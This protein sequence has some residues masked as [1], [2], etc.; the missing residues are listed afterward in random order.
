MPAVLPDRLAPAP[1]DMLPSRA[2]RALRAHWWLLLLQGTGLLLLGLSALVLPVL[3]T[4]VAEQLFGW[5]FIAAGIARLAGLPGLR[6]MNGGAWLAAGSAAVSIVAG[7]LLL[8]QPVAGMFALTA[9]L[10]ALFL[11]DGAALVLL[12]TF[13]L[14][15]IDGPRWPSILPGDASAWWALACGMLDIALAGMIAIGWPGV[16]TWVVGTLLGV[17]LVLGGLTL[18]LTGIGLRTPDK[19]PSAPPSGGS[20]RLAP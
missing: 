14:T 5:I 15:R 17:N 9:M 6:H 7:S 8:L 4:L 1:G 18:V 19:R 12:A 13:C 3:A 2:V 10:A 11:A 16:T 20:P